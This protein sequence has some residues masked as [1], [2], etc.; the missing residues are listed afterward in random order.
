MDPLSSSFAH[1]R[2][3]LGRLAGRI[4]A[5]ENRRRNAW[6]V[7]CLG[8]E[9]GDRVL[10]IGFGPGTTLARLDE[11]VGDG[12][13]AGVDASPEMAAQARRR[14]AAGVRD[15]RIDLR[16]ASAAALPFA[17]GVFDRALAVNSLHNLPD[18]AAHLV[19]VRRV[20]R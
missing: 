1:P 20:L 18:P 2:G 10:E 7:S 3:L 12:R 5:V 11:L 17:D 14:N 9:P 15:G 19:E 16:L 4:M 13:V 6:A 8:V